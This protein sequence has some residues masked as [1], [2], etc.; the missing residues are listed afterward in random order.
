VPLL[1]E[2]PAWF[3]VGVAVCLGLALGSFLNVVIYRVPLGMSLVK[4]GST[5]PRCNTPIKSYD[6]IPVF[7]YLL[8]RGKSR[9]CKVRISPRYPLVEASGGMLAWAIVITRIDMLPSDTPIHSAGLIFALYLALGL[10]LLAASF[11]DLDHMYV[12]DA[13]TLGGTVLGLASAGLRPAVDYQSA[14][15][16]AVVGFLMIWL[17]FDVLYRKLRG[18]TGMAMGD[19]K[20]VMLAGAWFGLPGALFA[21]LA[22]AV[23]GTLAALVVFLVHGS[24]EEPEAVTQERE[25]MRQAIAHS[26]GEERKRLEAEFAQDPIGEEAE[27]GLMGARLAFG[28]FLALATV[29]Y[30]LF[31]EVIV[32][33]LLGVHL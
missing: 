9:C 3:T 33:E 30:M 27:P 10:G 29:E 22:G 25:E 6:N 1:V 12:P 5:C 8:L 11:I 15:V 24:I 20:L 17:P 28:P 23:Q 4:P 26:E 16:G 32:Y 7:G 2:F 19:A 14:I 18:K 13:I 31:G 21:L